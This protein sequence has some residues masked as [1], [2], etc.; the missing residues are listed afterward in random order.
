MPVLDE[1][2]EL[3]QL[4]FGTASVSTLFQ[5]KA[6]KDL[7]EKVISD[8]EEEEALGWTID[9]VGV[10]DTPLPQQTEEK[11]SNVRKA[12][13]SDDDDTTTINISAI[14]RARKLR[15]T[16]DETNVSSAD[17]ESRL[18]TYFAKDTPSWATLPL[19]ED[20]E[21]EEEFIGQ[22]FNTLA[23]AL[24]IQVK[25]KFAS[26]ALDPDFIAMVRLKDANLPAYSSATI[27]ETAFHPTAPVVMTAGL[28]KTLRLFQITAKSSVLLSSIHLQNFPLYSCKMTHDGK[29]VIMTSRRK[30]FYVFDLESGSIKKIPYLKGT[31]LKSLERMV[32][33]PDN[34][35][36][37]VFGP[38]GVLHLVSLITKQWV[39]SLQLNAE[40]V[41]MCFTSDGATGYALGA[42]GVIYQY[43]MKNFTCQSTYLDSSLV[44]PTK[45][46]LSP[47][48]L[49]MAVGTKSG[50]VNIYHVHTTFTTT[51]SSNVRI[52]PIKSISN[53]LTE[54]QVMTFHPTS[55][56]LLIASTKK[57]DA[58][59][60]VHVP[61][62]RVYAN[63]PTSNTPLSY[64][65]AAAFS[66]DGGHL[67]I[68]NEKGKVL[69][70]EMTALLKKQYQKKK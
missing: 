41:D 52:Q 48:G 24:G 23:S 69:F 39:R 2:E 13:W 32:L 17:Y 30:H 44:H 34:A 18:R 10:E 70:Y 4:L 9:T 33:T 45:M 5:E 27:Q 40:V 66:P 1:E 57:K 11:K 65:T 58:L 46:C 51:E 35:Y 67:L 62:F 29:Q 37:V 6:E 22:S 42:D 31:D 3:T 63:W 36:M 59:K 15:K 60:L 64:V 68:G 43:N 38:Q 61:S 50:F 21:H 8:D 12:A 26:K 20:E 14:K 28:D 53:L 19:A 49:H 7:A 47:D 16:E 25:S 54:I 55:S 56:L